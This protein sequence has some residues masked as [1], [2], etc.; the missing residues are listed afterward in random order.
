MGIVVKAVCLVFCRYWYIG[1]PVALLVLLK[2]YNKLSMGIYKKATLMS[3]KTVIVTGATSGIGEATAYD[4]AARGARVILACRDL[5]KANGLREAIIEATKNSQVVVKKL[6]LSSLDSVREFA[7]QIMDEEKYIHV[8]INNAGTGGAKPK[9][10]KDGLQLA[11]QVNHFGHFLLTN[12]LL[13]KIRDSAPSRI[14]NVSSLA[15]RF[16]KLS[17][18]DMQCEQDFDSWTV[19]SN[20]KLCNILT[21]LYLSK[22]LTDT[23]VTANSVHPGV[24]GTNIFNTMKKSS[25]MI[26]T[27]VTGFINAFCK[28]SE[29]GAQTQIWAACDPDLE[30]VSGKYFQDCH[31]S[32]CY[33]SEIKNITL[34]ELVWNKSA[35]LVKLTKSE[36]NY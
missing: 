8:L 26:Y 6:D 12:L 22:L 35:E 28:S 14:I 11:M 9:I 30:N 1:F 19:Y 24:V 36:I 33:S 25:P 7:A 10:T 29:Q 18:S 20:S 3:G 21:T 13:G 15:H 23:G 32:R 5:G 17:L 34:A 27:L 31:E 16:N 4:L 2:I